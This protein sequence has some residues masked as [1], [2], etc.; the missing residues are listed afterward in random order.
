MARQYTN[1]G[2]AIWHDDDFRRLSMPAQHLYFVL[3]TDPDL[4]YAGI[5]DWRPK[6]ISGKAEA[7]LPEAVETAA[8]ELAAARFVYICE[9]TEEILVRSCVRHS[10]ALRNA[11]LAV[12]VANA[13][14][15]IASNDLRAVAVAEMKRA[16]K[17]EPELGAWKHASLKAVLG[18][19]SV[20]HRDLDPFGPDLAPDLGRLMGGGSDD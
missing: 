6:R 13:V 2:V 12:S 11:K 9:R 1:I 10:G 19:V 3:S 17:E 20:D 5:A 8:H 7:W 18:R 15:S 16:K 4:T 14:A